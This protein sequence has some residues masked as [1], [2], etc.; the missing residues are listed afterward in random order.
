MVFLFLL[1]SLTLAGC[2]GALFCVFHRPGP[3]L[4]EQPAT[5]PWQPSPQRKRQIVHWPLKLLPGSEPHHLCSRFN[6][7]SKSLSHVQPQ[8]YGGS[9]TSLVPR[10]RKAGKYPP[11]LV[12]SLSK[13]STLTQHLTHGNTPSPRHPWE[14]TVLQLQSSLQCSSRSLT[15]RCFQVFRSGMKP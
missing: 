6:S 15:F 11:S 10:K 12:R 9:A 4:K 13:W 1:C 7:Q 14:C 3:R 8:W 2:L 5:A